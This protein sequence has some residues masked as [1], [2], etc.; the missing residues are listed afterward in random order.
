[1][2]RTL[3]FVLVAILSMT[4]LVAVSAQQKPVTIVHWY[5]ADNPSYSAQM[6]KIAADF[7]AT[8]GKGITVVAQEYPWDGGAYSETLFRAV[9]G[10][11]VPDT[12]SF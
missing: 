7:N 4:A 1:M 12:S 6:Q 8:N 3:V 9:M 5:W 11:G 2:K 10:A